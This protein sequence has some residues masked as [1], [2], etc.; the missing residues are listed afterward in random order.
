MNGVNGCIGTT[1]Q[2][3]AHTKDTS[4]SVLQVEPFYMCLFLHR[5]HS[6]NGGVVV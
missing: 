2:H 6:I 5:M 3:V 1:S 4:T